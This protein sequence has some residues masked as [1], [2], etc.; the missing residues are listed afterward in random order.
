M[1]GA[2]FG[3]GFVVGPSMGALLSLWDVSKVFSFIPGI[4]PFSGPA[5]V[6]FVLAA[7]NFYLV[8]TKFPETLHVAEGSSSH[9]RRPM[10]PLTLLKPSP[11]V[12]VNKT[13][14]LYFIFIAAFAGMEFTLT[15]LAKDRFGYSAAR[16][17]LLFLYI[18]VLIALVQGGIVRR[19]GPKYGERRLATVGLIMV[20]PGLI[21][22][23]WC[24]L[25][26]TSPS[27]RDATLSRMPSSA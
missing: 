14:L 17:G 13:N 4:N 24:C 1:I 8:L 23:G 7:F 12:G 2:A 18:G 26:Y 21:L 11:F 10:N 25:L 6:A 15:F 20:V 9:A 3:L 27:P 16:N 22:V 5:L 19:L